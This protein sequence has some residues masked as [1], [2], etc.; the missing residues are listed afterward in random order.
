MDD[1]LVRLSQIP[2]TKLSI[3]DA[4]FRRELASLG[5]ANII[6]VLEL[7]LK[8]VDQ[9]L[10]SDANDLLDKL[11]DRYKKDPAA[12]ARYVLPAS[13]GV[14][15]P[16]DAAA[17]KTM[18]A[19]DVRRY[20]HASGPVVTS[21]VK[22]SVPSAVSARP[23]APSTAIPH[24]RDSPQFLYSNRNVYAAVPKDDWFKELRTLNG[25]AR[26]VFDDLDDRCDA[27]MV[28]MSFGVFATSLG[29]VR[30]GFKS[31]FAY[32]KNRHSEALDLID[33]YLRDIYLVYLADRAR[34]LYDGDAL[35]PNVFAEI[36]VTSQNV[37]IAMKKLFVSQLERR[38]MPRYAV[39]ES[40][41]YYLYTTLMH[42]GLSEDLWANLWKKSVLPF[43]D[44]LLKG[45]SLSSFEMAG[46]SLLREVL[47]PQSRY[48]PNNSVRKILEKAPS[49]SVASILVSALSVA[50]QVS[51][52]TQD[53]NRLQMLSSHGLPDTAMLALRRMLN[54][55]SDGAGAQGSG[56]SLAYFPEAELNLDLDSG[57]VLIGWPEL[58]L[59]SSLGGGIV[60][61]VINGE[62]MH[63][64]PVR[65]SV[66]KCLLSAVKIPVSPCAKYLVEL[67]M[68][69]E[70]PA[71]SFRQSIHRSRPGCFEFIE[72]KRG[73]YRLRGAKERLTKTRKIAY[74]AEEGLEV[75]PVCGMMAGPVYETDDSWGKARAQVFTVEPGASGSIVER[76]TG[77]EVAVWHESYRVRVS[78][79]GRIGRTS[80]GLDL[81]GESPDHDGFNGGLPLITITGLEGEGALDDLR[82]EC[83]CDGANVSVVRRKTVLQRGDG[84]S[85]TTVRLDL[86]SSAFPSRFV[87]SCVIAVWQ[88]PA[89]NSP[90]YRYR[91]AMAPIRGFR[92]DALQFAGDSILAKYCF[93]SIYAMDI[94][95]GGGESHRINAGGDY[96]VTVPLSDRVLPVSIEAAM[97][98]T[99]I[100]ALFDL[101][102]VDIRVPDELVELSEQRP[103][104]LYDAL[105]LG[106]SA[107]RLSLGASDWRAGRA[108]LIMLGD[109]LLF[110]KSMDAPGNYEIN[111]FEDPKIFLPSSTAAKS[112]PLSMIIWYGRGYEN[113]SV[114]RAFADTCLL[115]CSEGLG[116][117]NVVLYTDVSSKRYLRFDSPV[118]CDC[119][120]WFT[121][122]YADRQYGEVA[123]PS[124][125]TKIE[126]PDAA[127]RAHATHRKVRV[128]IMTTDIFGG[129]E[130]RYPI[131][132]SLERCNSHV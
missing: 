37:Q 115:D 129:V 67:R 116:F 19:F 35:W 23:Q 78:K 79:D 82:I 12:F 113:N 33:R 81:Y 124:G 53:G 93:K 84:E 41:Y 60:E 29:A 110:Y 16:K 86:A 55:G 90:I 4:R 57:C 102:A 20:G 38:G 123:I 127:V 80:E 30:N 7:P 45:S 118:L 58:R 121:G 42:G 66:N 1:D 89:S 26:E 14:S 64:E 132:F 6:E 47:N 130:E 87:E 11:R 99:S 48:A 25:E 28:H 44:Q 43:C 59:P 56:G 91:F 2:V 83:V 108:V 97:R 62:L 24:Y 73:T 18:S 103:I 8:T 9:K 63:S 13:S 68:G 22:P 105:E 5:C 21:R 119:V 36:G 32:Y 52:P 100:N 122:R 85:E 126:V 101:A 111:L 106:S 77:R 112:L 75:V 98:D 46:P 120:A 96:A 109:K 131:E 40:D 114:R 3:G 51:E 128:L 92:I 76:D 10:S 74:L 104:C 88:E 95:V 39:G 49:A 54:K 107:G 31:L 50:A 17:Q 70:A 71:G 15:I 61:Y 125:A 94:S 69:G 27:V 117:R 34:E 72:T 65:Y